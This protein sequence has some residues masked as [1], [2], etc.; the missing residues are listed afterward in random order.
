M[1]QVRPYY[2]E[3]SLSAAYYDL[4]TA[5]DGSLEGDIE[6]YAGLAPAGSRILEV[7]TGTGRIAFALAEKG[8]EVVGVDL[9]PTMLRQA[10]AKLATAD[11]QVAGRLT[12]VQGDMT[13][14][15]VDGPF[16]AAI[17]PFFTLAHAPRGAAWRNVFAGLAPRLAPGALA[18]FHMP[19]EGSLDQPPPKGPKEPVLAVR[20]DGGRVLQLFI[21]ERR[22]RPDIGR[23]D[24]VL[25]YVLLNARGQEERRSSERLTFY[26]GD[27]T[28]FAV[29]AGLV[30][31]RPPVPLGAS[32]E[33][34]VFRKT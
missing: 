4:L 32:G 6:L 18:A 31:D 33:V 10:R 15:S 28:S 13:A 1:V 11:P 20:V 17:Y 30:P 19:T 24:Q 14:L 8:F 25:D 27:P 5:M 7:G 29:E 2:A 16:A 22:R 12:F 21:R 9:A 34:F 3:Q 23:Y 26:A